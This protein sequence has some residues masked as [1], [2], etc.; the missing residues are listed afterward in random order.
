MTKEF[1]SFFSTQFGVGA[2]YASES[3]VSK[4]ELPDM[5]KNSTPSDTSAEP[6]SLT[7]CAADLVC[8]Y[9]AGEPIEF[10]DIPVD[11][12]G[13]SLFRLKALYAI[14]SVNYGEIR[15]YGEIAILC[16][17]PHAARAVGGAMA[18]NP[19]PIIIPCHR[20]V[21]GGGGLTGFSAPGGID[22]KRWLLEMEGVE[23]KRLLAIQKQLVINK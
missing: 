3:A 21:G 1:R 20:I 8:R 13:L 11:L 12:A 6:S 15:S 14:R 18:A 10:A 22:M 17:S 2:V 9:F 19:V 5:R 16:G 7:E 23:F 4:V